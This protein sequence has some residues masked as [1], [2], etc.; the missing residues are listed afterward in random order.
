VVVY[1][2]RRVAQRL[3][4]KSL[5]LSLRRPVKEGDKLVDDSAPIRLWR[6]EGGDQPLGLDP[7]RRI[8]AESGL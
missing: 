3:C 6:D 1:G 4:R 5:R 8:D 7:Q 2:V